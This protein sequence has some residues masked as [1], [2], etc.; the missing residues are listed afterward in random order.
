M[1]HLISGLFMSH[2][3]FGKLRLVY[4][5]LLISVKNITIHVGK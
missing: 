2:F 4:L 1:L 3:V 5:F